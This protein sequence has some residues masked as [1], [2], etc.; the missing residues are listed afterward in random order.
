MAGRGVPAGRQRAGGDHRVAG[1]DRLRRQRRPRDGCRA[2]R[3]RPLGRDHLV[4]RDPD[5]GPARHP[6]RRRQRARRA[7]LG[8]DAVYPRASESLVATAKERGTVVAE[9]PPGTPPS[10]AGFLA[11]ARLLAALA[12]G[13]VVVEAARRSNAGWSATWAENLGRGLFAVPGPVTSATSQLP[14][15]LIRDGRARLVT[16]TH[17]VLV[18]CTAITTE[19]N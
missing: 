18:D 7:G 15:Q 17:D 4:L 8:I 10:R 12:C 2:G 11:S 16:S 1:L 9:Q 14:H 3:A 6:G 19:E 5:R 13:T